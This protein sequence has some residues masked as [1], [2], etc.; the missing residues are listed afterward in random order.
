MIKVFF[1][2][3]SFLPL[4]L[5]SPYLLQAWR[6]SRL[7]RWDWIFYLTAIPAAV[8]ALRK[9]KTGKL[10]FYALFLLLPSLFLTAFPSF[11]HI[12]AL[13]VASAVGV[14]FSAVWLLGAWPFAYRLLPAAVILL[15]GTPSSSYQLSLLMM[16]PVWAAWAVKFFLAVLCLV[17]IECNQRFS[18]Q[19]K[20]GTLFFSAAVL[21]TG[22]ILLHT[23]ELYFEGKSFIPEFGTRCGGF[24]GRRME[25]DG[26]TKRFFATGNVQQYRYTKNNTDISVLAVRCGRNIHEIHPASHCLRTGFWTVFSEKILYLQEDFAVTE[27][28]ARKGDSHILVWVWY[29]S[30]R[31]ST[32][33]FL[34]F[35][36]H[37]KPGGIYYTYQISIPLNGSDEAGRKELKSFVQTLKRKKRP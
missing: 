23:R 33:G 35:R 6:S 4:C 1:M 12:H 27:I 21:M 26:N 10:D 24:W 14:I 19:I 28:N 7:D 17:W 2:L 11:H 22:F 5:H 34:G 8:W 16:C 29:S 32:P 37:F 20:R 36:R 13:S 3:L 25:P 30:E 15:L 9:V 18:V 31:F